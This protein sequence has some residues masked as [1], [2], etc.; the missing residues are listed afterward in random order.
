MSKSPHGHAA[1]DHAKQTGTWLML[2]DAQNGVVPDDLRE[3]LGAVEIAATGF[4]ALSPFDQAH[5]P[6]VDRQRET[7]GDQGCAPSCSP[8]SSSASG[9]CATRSAPARW[10]R[11]TPAICTGT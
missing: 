4:D 6:G 2:A 10:Q 9:W 7:A 8:R 3:Q 5:V 1:V 11:P